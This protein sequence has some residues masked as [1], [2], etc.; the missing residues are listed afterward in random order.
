LAKLPTELS[1]KIFEHLL[2]PC[3]GD[4]AW[5]KAAGTLVMGMAGT[6]K[7]FTE[8]ILYVFWREV[9]HIHITTSMVNIPGFT[10]IVNTLSRR[11][12]F[13]RPECGLRLDMVPLDIS[14][15]E[16]HGLVESTRKR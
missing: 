12:F 9:R 8:E 15:V 14:H 11:G 10:A 3:D 13:V 2:R 16:F 7:R 1:I 5:G 6:N 4:F